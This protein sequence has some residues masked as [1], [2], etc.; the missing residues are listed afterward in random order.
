[1]HTCTPEACSCLFRKE[2]ASGVFCAIQ[3]RHF[4]KKTDRWVSSIVSAFNLGIEGLP[5]CKKPWF[6]C[7]RKE[8]IIKTPQS[9]LTWFKR[10]LVAP[11][12][13]ATYQNAKMSALH[14]S[15]EPIM[16]VLLRFASNV[17]VH[18]FTFWLWKLFISENLLSQ[19]ECVFTRRAYCWLFIPDWRVA[20]FV[21]FCALPATGL[22]RSLLASCWLP[23][24][25]VTSPGRNGALWHS[26]LGTAW[27]FASFS[28][29]INSCLV[30]CP[31]LA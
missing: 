27:S 22:S 31:T 9:W 18:T 13:M 29:L 24:M 20:G 19:C 2:C 15:I 3:S 16:I 23:C 28:R 21:G 12:K 1:M 14:W 17:C 26:L 5:Q 8:E 11:A 30:R 4:C 6:W 10:T 7:L 25:N